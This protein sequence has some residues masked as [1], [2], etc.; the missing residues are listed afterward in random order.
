MKYLYVTIARRGRR[1]S[2]TFIGTLG[3]GVILAASAGVFAEGGEDKREPVRDNG[4]AVQAADFPI[5]E[6]LFGLSAPR[7]HGRILIYPPGMDPP[8]NVNPDATT[9]WKL[10]RLYDL[11]GARKAG[12]VIS[13]EALPPR[14][15]VTSGSAMLATKPDGSSEYTE[16]GL[17]IT[18]AGYPIDVYRSIPSQHYAN[19]PYSLPAWLD[20][21]VMT[22]LGSVRGIPAVFVHKRAGIK[23]P[24]LQQVF[25]DDGDRV[26]LIEGYVDEFAKL[27]KIAESILANAGKGDPNVR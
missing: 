11:E 27:V 6:H 18:G 26:I 13:P 21:N 25:V 7:L 15:A 9:G 8:A 16:S 14:Y 1:L 4:G 2:Y 22:T 17:Q 3:A 24:E 12:L 19:Q 20:G 10:T 23:T 5:G